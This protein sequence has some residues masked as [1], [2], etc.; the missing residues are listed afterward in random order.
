V[1]YRPQISF[2]MM[3]HVHAMTSVYGAE[4]LLVLVAAGFIYMFSPDRSRQLLK[5]VALSVLLF[6]IGSMLLQAACSACRQ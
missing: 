2:N 1:R 3:D 5:N 4:L 6:T